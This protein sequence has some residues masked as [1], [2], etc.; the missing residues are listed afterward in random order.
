MRAHSL[1]RGAVGRVSDDLDQRRRFIAERLTEDS[2]I[3]TKSNG[4]LSQQ[5]S[6]HFCQRDVPAFECRPELGNRRRPLVG[7]LQP[8][9]VAT[10]RRRTGGTLRPD[11]DLLA[12][13]RESTGQLSTEPGEATKVWTSHHRDGLLVGLR[14]GE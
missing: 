11:V 1:R 9:V 12:P 13:V 4:P 7:P 8:H 2:A 14:E 3:R 5:L 6:P 10:I